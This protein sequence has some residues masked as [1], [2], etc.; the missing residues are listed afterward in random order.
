[1]RYF[2]IILL[3]LQIS[4]FLSSRDFYMSLIHVNFNYNYTVTHKDLSVLK[5]STNNVHHNVRRPTLNFCRKTKKTKI[6]KTCFWIITCII[7]RIPSGN[8]YMKPESKTTSKYLLSH[9]LMNATYFRVWKVN[10]L[11]YI[12][13]F[14]FFQPCFALLRNL[15]SSKQVISAGKTHSDC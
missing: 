13:S 12:F 14:H 7:G 6:F 1:M 5:K 10:F 2:N 3:I 8:R 11:S 4:H 15:Y 9:D